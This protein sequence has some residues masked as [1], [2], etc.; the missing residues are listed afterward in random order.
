MTCAREHS[1]CLSSYKKKGPWFFSLILCRHSVPCAGKQ[2]PYTFQNLSLRGIISWDTYDIIW[3]CDLAMPYGTT[4]SVDTS[5]NNTQLFCCV[6]HRGQRREV[7]GWVGGAGG[8]G[9]AAEHY[10]KICTV[11]TVVRW[12]SASSCLCRGG[13]LGF[14]ARSVSDSGLI[15]CDSARRKAGRGWNERKRGRGGG[16]LYRDR[17]S[18]PP[19]IMDESMDAVLCTFSADPA[20]RGWGRWGG[21]RPVAYG[22]AARVW[23]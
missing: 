12:A 8:G 17:P 22:M 13:C 19:D 5:L 20:R 7:G 10:A 3:I 15:M 2:L 23:V 4:G 21:I 18:P 9:E 11:S 16:S 6:E 1:Q 14:L